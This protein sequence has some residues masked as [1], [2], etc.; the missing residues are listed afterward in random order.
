MY[1][2]FTDLAR[3]TMR[4]ANEKAA[5]HKH[6]YIGTEHI[7]LALIEIDS[8]GRLILYHLGLTITAIAKELWKAVQE[9][10]EP[11]RPGKL[12][13]TPRAKKVIEY[14]MEESR[15]LK[16]SFV[17]TEHL[18]LGLLREEEGIA[19]HVLRTLGVQIDRARDVL[20]QLRNDKNRELVSVRKIAPG[21]LLFQLDRAH[22]E[23]AIDPE[24]A[25]WEKARKG[26]Q[27]IE[28]SSIVVMGKEI[29]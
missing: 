18:L 27:G 12:P 22:A 5:L 24:A 4:L 28:I 17:G 10:P 14:A 25:L 1:E 6:E 21:G 26:A 15:A 19:A 11:P 2:R 13:Q 23:P 20:L 16:D 29:T 3:N 7:L 9:G 8:E